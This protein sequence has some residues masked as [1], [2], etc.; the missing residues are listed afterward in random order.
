MQQC[1]GISQSVQPEVS[2]AEAMNVICREHQP[3]LMLF[4]S[5]LKKIQIVMAVMKSKGHKVRRS[6]LTFINWKYCLIITLEVDATLGL[7]HDT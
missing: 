3:L 7:E 4:E 2:E 1:L 5:R 6:F